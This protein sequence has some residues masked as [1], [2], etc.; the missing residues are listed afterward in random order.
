MPVAAKGFTLVE[1]IGVIVIAGILATVAAP[2]FFSAAT[3]ASR[4]YADAAA[5]FL[6]HTQKLAIARHGGV[7]VAVGSDGL[8]LCRVACKLRRCRSDA[9]TGW[10]HALPGSCAEW[11][12][13]VRRCRQPQLRRTGTPR[14]C[15]YPDHHR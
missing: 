1:L 14:P 12:Q 7:S 8:T 4:G 9:G 2:R 11:R 13:P 15:T 10:Q 6:R 5:A 3:F